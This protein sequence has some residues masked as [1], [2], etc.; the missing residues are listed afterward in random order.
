MWD[1]L[2]LAGANVTEGCI[3]RQ[4]NRGEQREFTTEVTERHREQDSM[5]TLSLCAPVPSL[6]NHSWVYRNNRERRGKGYVRHS[7]KT[8]YRAFAL[9]LGL[10]AAFLGATEQ[11]PPGQATA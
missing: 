3:Q 9:A 4:Q 1:T 7:G 6:V 10:A 5:L 11:T 8:H 2:T